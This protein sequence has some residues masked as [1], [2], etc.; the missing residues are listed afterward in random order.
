VSRRRTLKKLKLQAKEARAKHQLRL[1]QKL[2]KLLI[3]IKPQLITKKRKKLRKEF[4][5]YL[6]IM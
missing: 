6:R 3:R 4:F 5:Q 2:R 1:L